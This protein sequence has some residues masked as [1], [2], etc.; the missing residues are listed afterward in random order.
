MEKKI[1]SKKRNSLL[2]SV[3]VLISEIRHLIEQTR[4]KVAQTVNSPSF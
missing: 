4:S 2:K 1:A 3:E